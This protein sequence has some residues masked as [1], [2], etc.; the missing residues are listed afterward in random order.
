MCK[1][2]CIYVLTTWYM[3]CLYVTP[4]TCNRAS[5]KWNC[6][7]HCNMHC[8]THCNTLCNTHCNTHCNTYSTATGHRASA[9]SHWRSTSHKR[10]ALFPHAGCTRQWLA[11]RSWFLSP[12]ASGWVGA[13]TSLYGRQRSC[14]QV[15]AKERKRGRESFGVWQ[16]PRKLRSG[17]NTSQKQR[18]RTRR[19]Q[20]DS[21]VSTNDSLV[22]TGCG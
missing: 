4:A 20:N 21:L 3:L 6:N 19:R 18:A 7:T 17:D 22:S 16:R 14:Q 13:L 12:V 9:G 8:N 15:R 1:Y 2:L 10:V 5:S 11:T